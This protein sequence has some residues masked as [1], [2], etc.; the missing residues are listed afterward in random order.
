MYHEPNYLPMPFDGPL[1]LTLCDM[2]CFDHPETHPVERVR[3]MQ[4]HLPAAIARAD[5]LI[6]ISKDSGQ[7]LQRW[8]DVPS[9]RI[10]TTYLAADDRF[11]PHT[12]EL[13]Q[14]ALAKMDLTPQGYVLCVGTL[15]PRKNLST[16]FAAFAGLPEPLRKRYPLVVA[17]M[18]GWNTDDLMKSAQALIRSG[19]L[20]LLGYVKDELIAPLY[21]GASV[22]CYPSR[23]EGFGLPALEAMASGVPVLT[24]NRTSLPEVVGSAGLMVDPDDVGSMRDSLRNL[25]E[26]RD[27]AMRLAAAGLE[28]STTFSWNRCALETLKV[29]EQVAQARGLSE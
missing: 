10:T 27:L 23:Y 14:P 17:G 8:F 16:L 26:D 13:L 29:Y 12:T 9:E 21:A 22:F 20:R 15:E 28:R 25:L 18:S 4:H 3:L 6:V 7:A 1:V 2:S 19:E 24:T 11:K 5:H